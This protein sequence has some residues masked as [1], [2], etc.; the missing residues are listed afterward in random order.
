MSTSLLTKKIEEAKSQGRKALIPFLPGGF[1]DRDRFWQELEALDA[2]GADIIEIGVPFSDPVADGPVV[3]NASLDCLRDGVCLSWILFELE[4]RKEKLSA[5]IVLMG[6]YNPFLQYGLKNF[7]RDAAKA[8]VSGVIVPDLP[9]DE[10]REFK[11]ALAAH[12]LDLVFLV[13][14]NTSGERLDKYAA[15]ASGFIYFVSVLGTTGVRETLP[16]EIAAKLADAR[17]H[18]N[19]PMALGFGIKTPEQLTA[20][21]DSIDAV[22]FGSAL[23][24]YIR[25]GGDATGFMAGWR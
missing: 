8:G 10:A 7:A 16:E 21:G 13:G 23:I 24:K 9:L 19:V 22:V 5:G 25:D 6:Y 15:V 14:L 20:F 18:F 3:E 2:A 11:D 1:P 12:G 17:K 4:K